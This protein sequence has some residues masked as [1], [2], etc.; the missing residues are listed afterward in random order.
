M[1]ELIAVLAMV[2]VFAAAAIPSIAGFI[3]HGKQINRTNIARTLYLA[4][5]SE[6][7]KMRTEGGMGE[8]TDGYFQ[9][10]AETGAR[11]LLVTADAAADKRVWKILETGGGR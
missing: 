8:L 4:A 7:V 3:E 9:A 5:Q 11:E 1:V 2:A 6:L 10:N